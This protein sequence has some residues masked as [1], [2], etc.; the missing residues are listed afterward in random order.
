MEVNNAVYPE[1][2][3]LIQLLKQGHKGPVRMINLLKFHDRAQYED[4]RDPDLS[5]QE[6]YQRYGRAMVKIVEANGGRPVAS[7]AII[8]QVIGQVEELW[9]F[10]ALFEYPS[11]D[12]FARIVS[13]PEVAELSQHRTAGLKGQL[14]IPI[15]DQ[16]FSG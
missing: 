7:G 11:M 1:R 5:G 8:G 14:L 12:E 4:G 3:V 15:Q 2:E 16:P 6:A 9:D 10:F 13:L